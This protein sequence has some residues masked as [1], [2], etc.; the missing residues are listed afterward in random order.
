MDDIWAAYYLQAKGARV[1]WTKPSVYQARNVH[2]LVHDMK[3]EYCG[4]ESNIR[5]VSDL[6][7][8]PESLQAYLP[9]RSI[10]AFEL[11]RRHFS[12]A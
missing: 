1:V 2:D 4:Y 9:G 3:Q 11:Y 8:D 10:R 7:Q 6:V 5:I 12:D